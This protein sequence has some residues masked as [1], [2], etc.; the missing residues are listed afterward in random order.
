[1]VRVTE[2]PEL[3]VR[4][5]FREV[6][7]V[8][9]KEMLRLWVRGHGYK[10]IARLTQIDRKTVRRY[11]EAAVRVGM[12]QAG[13]E[14]QIT[15]GLVG[16]VINQVRPARH[17]NHGQARAHLDAHREF[18]KERL[19]SGLTLTK[20]ASLL[21][22]HTGVVVA[23]RTFHR[24]CAAELGYRPGRAATVRVDD[25]EP[26]SEL[27]VD[28][29]R[30]GLVLDP[31]AGRRRIAHALIFT[32][33][34]SRHLFVYLTFSQALESLISGFEAA[35]SFFGVFK[36]VIPDNMKAIVDKAD[37][38]NPRLNAAFLDYVQARG[39]V[40]DPTRVRSPQDKPRVERSV[41]FVRNSFF[42]G[43]SFADLADAQAKAVTWCR[44]EAGLRIH[45]T[46]A[47][48]PAEVFAAEEMALLA[49]EP[50]EPYDVPI[51]AEPKVARDYHIEVCRALYSVPCAYIGQRVQVRADSALVRAYH[52]GSL[53][54][55]HPRKPPGGR[56]TDPADYPTDKAAYATRD[57]D[58][59]R[60]VCAAH[61]PNVGTY[62]TELLA[63]ELPWTKM[64]QVYRL[65]GL[66]R[67]YGPDPVDAACAKALEVEV[68]DVTRIARML[69]RALE[70]SPALR[71]P[72]AGGGAVVLR[73]ARSKE[74]F[75][76]KGG[77]R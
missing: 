67:T 40:V 9:V 66:V 53:I 30:M 5:V 12:R 59:L 74:D 7:V 25:P 38:V 3:E 8:E 16:E 34:Y 56:S 71:Q 35:W 31:V 36:V 70:S 13:G 58:Y 77:R 63:G 51:F 19:A 32:A 55:T 45:G 50:A 73:F 52:R 68:V 57:I 14:T 33:V 49:P 60:R 28:F 69:E 48:R 24:F 62:A 1:L 64:R 44:T 39:F 76:P 37:P 72:P 21:Y 26:G 75:A 11:V 47:R 20:I 6:D 41:P 27:Q 43:E 18:V 29:G 23:Y 46:T 42:A 15:E 4:M 17:P 10:S 2:S 65:L 54:K 61:G 22:R